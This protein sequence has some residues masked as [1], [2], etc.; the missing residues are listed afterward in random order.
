MKY[1]AILMLAILSSCSMMP[2]L[3]TEAEDL[4]EFEKDAIEHEVELRKD[5]K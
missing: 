4:V 5:V 1:I 3:M 2:Y